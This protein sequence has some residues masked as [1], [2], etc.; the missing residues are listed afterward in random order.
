VRK[1]VF[2]ILSMLGILSLLSGGEARAQVVAITANTTLPCG[3]QVVQAN[4]G[5]PQ[6]MITLPA[7]LTMAGQT[8]TVFKG[9]SQAGTSGNVAIQ[10]AGSQTINISTNPFSL[11]TN[12]FLLTNAN[13]Y[14]IFLSDGANWT[15]TSTNLAVTGTVIACPNQ[16]AVAAVTGNGAALAFYTCTIPAGMIKAGGGIEIYTL[17][18]HTTG[19]AN[20][21]YNVSF[22]GTATTA[23]TVTGSANQRVTIRWIVMNAAGSQSSQTIG[24]EF[25]DSNTGQVIELQDTATVNTANAVVVNVLFNVANTDAITPQI[26]YVR[27]IQ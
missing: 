25:N 22:G 2:I 19:S 12:P 5:A 18:K 20:I 26:S 7:C 4:T 14:A 13:D 27:L 8:I 6:L 1:R 3:Q 16:G 9:S 23:R 17:S 11:S 15:I 24:G 21:L 10:A